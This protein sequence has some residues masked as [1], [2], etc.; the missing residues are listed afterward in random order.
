[1]EATADRPGSTS[2]P[3]APGNGVD[4]PGGHASAADPAPADRA[5]RADDR[6]IPAVAGT[7][8]F[9]DLEHARDAWNRTA[10]DTGAPLADFDLV[11]VQAR[12]DAGAAGGETERLVTVIP[13]DDRLEAAIPWTL[14]R[15]RGPL[16]RVRFATTAGAAN[17]M[18]PAPVLFGP[19]SSLGD[20]AAAWHGMLQHLSDQA[21]PDAVELGP[22]ALDSPAWAG[23]L[24]A[25]DDHRLPFR[26]TRTRT[27][28]AWVRLGVD[29]DDGAAWRTRVAREVHRLRR[30]LGPEHT[31]RVDDADG[32]R[33]ELHEADRSLRRTRG[34]G[35]AAMPDGH[36]L[37]DG[38]VRAAASD[39][40][41]AS[42]A[43]RPLAIRI[44][45]GGRV[46][47]RAVAIVRGDRAVVLA[48]ACSRDLPWRRFA[49]GRIVFARLIDELAADGVRTIEAGPA[50][51]WFAARSPGAVAVPLRST[52]LVPRGGD[53]ALVEQMTDLLVRV[54]SLGPFERFVQRLRPWTEADGWDAQGPAPAEA[55]EP[56]EP[57]ESA[58]DVEAEADAD[59]TGADDAPHDD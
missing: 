18:L 54:P 51:V 33:A 52:L 31:V 15:L 38:L 5:D 11:R 34:G 16:S 53:R 2:A 17:G 57:A 59:V 35:L 4:R 50:A 26:A 6:P 49:P 45:H 7:P 36:S 58:A 40:R 29:P 12:H 41:P 32:V 47:G 22:L 48:V 44:E 23:L 28:G 30:T 1:V 9:A 56:A 3:R 39:D 27:C 8:G 20:V 14:E 10:H 37:M 13:A 42:H 21:A 46:I 25:L 24:I 19:D 55:A 43:T